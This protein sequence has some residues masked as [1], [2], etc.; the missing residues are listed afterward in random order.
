MTKYISQLN[1]CF[2]GR[3]ACISSNK[4][5]AEAVKINYRHLALD[6]NPVLAE[7]CFSVLYVIVKLGD[8]DAQK[9]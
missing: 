6:Y 9:G 2:F 7:L 5:Q 8:R 1:T 3:V 4:E